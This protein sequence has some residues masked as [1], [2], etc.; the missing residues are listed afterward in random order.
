MA[1]SQ[2]DSEW[3]KS[4]S[5]IQSEDSEDLF[6][7]RPNRWRGLPQ[8]WRTLTEEDRL[9]YNALERLR[10]RDL[11]T[12]LYNAFAL[13]TT[14]IPLVYQDVD[15]N[16]N[17]QGSQIGPWAPPKSW[18]A[19]PLRADL[20][21]PDDFMK[22]TEDQDETLTFRRLEAK[23]PSSPLEEVVSAAILRF[24][25]E[26]FYKRQLEEP[27]TPECG[28]SNR[29]NEPLSSGH[30]AS[31]VQNV[32]VGE[33]GNALIGSAQ[34]ARGKAVEKTYKPAV[35]T[36]DDASYELIRPSTRAIL[37]KLDQTLTILHN[38]R[39][40]SYRG[41]T[42]SASSSSDT[43]DALYNEATP[44]GRRS[45]SRAKSRSRPTS[46]ASSVAS[47]FRARSR[48][49]SRDATVSPSKLNSNRG[50]KVASVPREEESEREFRRRRAREQKKR[51]PVFSDDERSTAAE[52]ARSPRKRRQKQPR[53]R[54]GD[55]E[56]WSQRK[57][58]RLNLRDWS[59]VMGAAALAGFDARVIERATQRCANLFGQGMEMHI[60]D[61]DAELETKRYIPGRLVL[62]SDSESEDESEQTDS[63]QNRS[64]SRHSSLA[65]S[66]A[67]SLASIDGDE[68]GDER[69]GVESPRKRQR[70]S[71][72]RG[73]ALES[74]YCHH[75]GCDRAIRSFD[76]PGNLRRHLK[77]IHSEGD[78][79]ENQT[80]QPEGRELLSCPHA[81][82]ERAIR[83]FD[84]GHNLRRHLQLVHGEVT[85]GGSKGKAVM[86]QYCCPHD[87]CD[88][89]TR[90]FDRKPNL[91][92]HMKLVHGEDELGSQKQDQPSERVVE[93]RDK[94]TP[95]KDRR[96][97]PSD[98]DAP[99]SE[100]ESSTE[101]ESDSE[102]D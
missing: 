3:D 35:A 22:S 74:Y 59:D 48:S 75:A 2:D 25:K 43:E 64:V 62:S 41:L 47:N 92:R 69:R 39:N 91:K 57:L 95:K 24:A 51:L 56:Y 73:S 86:A 99:Q 45:R 4:T 100:E 102:S 37:S 11:S 23:A 29:K 18:T 67:I 36:D 87:D 77:L 34:A 72:S 44:S 78:W 55:G 76:R 66:R 101:A 83:P 17:S 84:K 27:C 68:H 14:P 65:Q 82:C 54:S 94:S 42:D 49:L 93:S 88:R 8:S 79:Q 20:V 61:E 53:A 13:K 98:Q 19:W 26:K 28:N 89:A 7:S 85:R 50:R 38:A 33:Q 30:E 32:S 21:P 52:G 1:S 5:E 46:R 15:A 31:S 12:H 71:S 70:R 80:P 10:N 60:I 6:E 81:D 16:L 90:P 96:E 58:D 9:T 97:G 40:T 63:P